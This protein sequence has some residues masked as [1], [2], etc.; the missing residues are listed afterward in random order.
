MASNPYN[1]PNAIDTSGS[2]T[3]SKSAV[4]AGRINPY[5]AYGA[6]TR[7]Q[8]TT[9]QQNIRAND[10]ASQVVKADNTKLSGDLPT[11]LANIKTL[12]NPD[13]QVRTLQRA[14]KAGLIDKQTAGAA[15]T[16]ILGNQP[17]PK[18][19]PLSNLEKA[20]KVAGGILNVGG[21][22]VA[23]PVEALQEKVLKPYVTSPA[24]ALGSAAAD[25]TGGKGFDF[26]KQYQQEQKGNQTVPQVAGAIDKNTGLNISAGVKAGDKNPAETL[27]VTGLV[28]ADTASGGALT[29]VIAPALTGYYGTKFV[30]GAP[31]A[32][33]NIKNT[34]NE[35]D[36]WTMASEFL[37]QAGL[38]GLGAKSSVSSAK[39]VLGDI[40]GTSEKPVA[41]LT[42]TV[43]GEST[44]VK[45][46]PGQVNDFMNFPNKSIDPAVK[47]ALTQAFNEGTVNLKSIKGGINFKSEDVTKPTVYGRIITAIQNKVNKNQPLTPAEQVIKTDVSNNPEKY[48]GTTAVAKYNAP[49]NNAVAPAAAGVASNIPAAPPV[50]PVD[51]PPGITH[52]AN[53][54]EA[55]T[56]IAPPTKAPGAVTKITP[57]AIEKVPTRPTG[58]I[59]TYAGHQGRG[60][61]FSTPD[62]Q[63]ATQ[64]AN[65]DANGHPVKGVVSTKVINKADVL[66]TRNPTDLQR[67]QSVLGAEPVQKMID[68][69][70]NGLP[71]H[72]DKGE[73]DALVK[74]AATLGYKHIALSETDSQTKYN[75]GHVISYVD[76]SP[77]VTKEVTQV[78]KG[79]VKPLNKPKAPV[80]A[81]AKAPAP[82]PKPVAKATASIE[83]P[84]HNLL[85]DHLLENVPKAEKYAPI[86][87]KNGESMHV[88]KDEIDRVALPAKFLNEAIKQAKKAKDTTSVLK[89]K[90]HLQEYRDE[91]SFPPETAHELN[92]YL[93]GTDKVKL[94]EATSVP[95]EKLSPTE[96]QSA[97]GYERSP[98][99]KAFV[100]DLLDS[101]PSIKDNPILTVAKGEDGKLMFA[102]ESKDGNIQFKLNP[103]KFGISPDRLEASGLKVGDTIN[104]GTMLEKGGGQIPVIKKGKTMFSG[105]SGGNRTNNKVTLSADD[106]SGIKSD[107]QNALDENNMDDAHIEKIYHIGSTAK[108]TAKTGSDIDILVT[109]SGTAR[110]DDVF[111]ALQDYNSS[112]KL[113]V[114]G[115]KIDFNP[116]KSSDT[117]QIN[118]L[119][120]GTPSETSSNSE[121]KEST[122][123]ETAAPK[124]SNSIKRFLDETSKNKEVA[125]KLDDKLH[126]LGGNTVA[127]N[128][129]LNHLF[130]EVKALKVS[131]TDWA[132]IYHYAENR[133]SPITPEQKTLFDTTIKPLQDSINKMRED[134]GLKPFK[135]SE[136]IHRIA[137]GRGSSLERYIQGDTKDISPGNVLKKTSDSMKTRTWMKLVD[138]QGNSKIVAIKTPKDKT[139]K[140]LGERQVTAF[141]KGKTT[142]MGA[143]KRKIPDPV[144]EFYD[145]K[146]MEQ[147]NSIA[148]GLGLEHT[149]TNVPLKRGDSAAGV[150]YGGTNQIKTKTASPA[151]TLLHEIG[152][153]IDEKYG[154]QEQFFGGS[155]PK[156]DMIVDNQIKK[157]ERLRGELDPN[158]DQAII[159]DYNQLIRQ[160]LEQK[161]VNRELRALADKRYE[162]FNP[163]NR[164]VKSFQK[165][166]R[167]G[168]EKM[169]VMFQAY[170]H[171]PEIF[172][173]VAPV[174]FDKFESFLKSHPETKPIANIKKSLI[175][176]SDTVG[177]VRHEGEFID[178]T[179]KKWQIVN[180]TTKEIE[181]NSTTR[182]F[183]QP[184]VSTAIDYMQTRQALRAS[185]FLDTWKTAPDFLYQSHEDGSTTGIAIKSDAKTIPDG[186]KTTTAMQFRGYHFEPRVAEV[187][188]DF[189][190]TAARGDPLS[191]FTGMNLFLR[192][193]IFYNPLMHVPNILWHAVMRRG[194]SG[195]V[196]PIRLVNGVTSSMQAINQVM[197]QGDLYQT[198]LR[199]GAPLM[200]FDRTALTKMIGKMMEDTIQ[201]DAAVSKLAKLA[202]YANKANFVKAW[203]KVSAG[204][205]WSSHDFFML[206][207]MIEEMKR[208]LTP[209][210]AIHEVTAHIPD[211][212]LPTRFFGSRSLKTTLAN[213]NVTMFLP[214][215]YGIFKSYANTIREMAGR[216]LVGGKQESGWQGK[217]KSSARGVD[218]LIMAG[219]IMYLIYPQLDRMAKAIFHDSNAVVR[220]AGPF[221]FPYAIYR[222]LSGH[223]SV[224]S[225]IQ[226]ILPTPPGTK[227]IVQLIRNR[228]DLNRQ[229]WNP[230]DAF[231]APVTAA[232]DIGKFIMGTV[233][234][235]ATATKAFTGKA[236]AVLES[237]F[238]VSSPIDVKSLASKL[239][240]QQLNLGV[241]SKAQQRILDQKNAARDQIAAGKGDALAKALVDQGVIKANK[242]KQFETT[243]SWT[244]LQ[245]TF[246]ALNMVNKLAILQKAS[247]LDWAQ[248]GD[249]KAI[250]AAAA[251]ASTSSK[252]TASD[253]LA[254]GDIV[255]LLNGDTGGYKFTNGKQTTHQNVIQ[256]VGA[257]ASA[258]ATSP[259]TAFNRIFTGQ[260]ILRTN[261]GAII[262]ERMPQTTSSGIRMQLGSGKSNQPMQLD[263]IIPLEIGGSNDIS[264]L[265]LIPKSQDEAN[266]PIENYLG[267]Q[268]QANKINAQQAKQ[269]ILDYKHGKITAADVYKH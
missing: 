72:V 221:T 68:S 22:I 135:N 108:G 60:S 5:D 129:A 119:L 23:A 109:Y 63:F 211:Y 236:K 260:R 76:T 123:T 229:I 24:A 112:N 209:Q 205:T 216:A 90:A 219:V 99:N 179:G 57:P 212:R 13:D 176:G 39:G 101:V 218:K 147:L 40:K 213:H 114:A 148:K 26:R 96:V 252:G 155:R 180:A 244:P 56:A 53:I 165:Y 220:R 74:A 182:Y 185:Q 10:V 246:D 88:T 36:K 83:F 113:E 190:K 191:A 87:M 139:G 103:E 184:L 199:E 230:S 49:E 134:M 258:F 67:L 31:Q 6:S 115:R 163:D 217:A 143:L 208:G 126:A 167:S 77:A 69:S 98:I 89:F 118:S 38:L 136:F 257:Y 268:L 267:K 173:A 169:A 18:A 198:M 130:K 256:I 141:D 127:D 181:A 186:W 237:F 146:V 241:Q 152:H 224:P 104:I 235:A 200:S 51:L 93:F 3:Y 50:A 80:K 193:T 161:T 164:G 133:S 2:Q 66:D 33:K 234:P 78:A 160:H 29:P 172:Q 43:P 132:A 223:K 228:D 75:G 65:E 94:G 227:G 197:H 266:N 128:V 238:G 4:K 82:A 37:T 210:E 59:T 116:V 97:T 92:Q 263:H 222:M 48:V 153:Q 55:P 21:N 137:Q 102:G 156:S 110:E 259:L 194:V 250:K 106:I 215:H 25:A 195:I 171:A 1:Q 138:E 243:A 34:P 46:T 183:K 64:F 54:P 124:P 174:T 27:G 245:R 154:L 121:P 188:D 145:P 122:P 9:D 12:A 125:G 226:T 177:D 47:A 255:K 70:G 15:V 81:I 14:S 42:K 144:H 7:D 162:G 225:T 16:S 242:L 158:K 239:L 157:L 85:P 203:Y 233:S 35:G 262:V 261:N 249:V 95:K 91:G 206:Q 100:K 253:K 231:N 11:D 45:V 248:L 251:K 168:E 107:V 131:S 111:N 71:A 189:A 86:P 120:K 269:L 20:G 254:A 19:Q 30:A 196:N 105:T 240:G 265:Q 166:V 202:G 140:A 192:N 62:K 52:P 61:A 204:V 73:Q 264:N 17:A 247:P 28:V 142:P 8:A 117:E 79:T 201:D 159:E 232:K 84:K 175:L 149:R 58:T 178:K 44:N 170:L 214:Y 187:L 41:P 32:I 151:D 150:S 207:A